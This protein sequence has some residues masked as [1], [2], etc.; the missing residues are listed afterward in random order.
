MS[1]FKNCE[2][3]KEEIVIP[4][5]LK[6]EDKDHYFCCHGCQTV[7]EILHDKKLQ[8]YYKFRD[9]SEKQSFTPIKTTNNKFNYLDQ[10]DFRNKYVKSNKNSYTLIFY[11][12]GIH[13]LACLWLIEKIPEFV[14]HVVASKLNMAK[15]TAEIT[16]T[17]EG[18]FATVAKQL[19]TLGYPPHPIMEDEDS[20]KLSQKEDHSQLIKIAISFFCAGNIMLMSFSV[21]AGATGAIKEYFD[22]LSLL[23]AIP[24]LTYSSTSFYKNAYS[25]VKNK[26]LSI[27]FPIVVAIILGSIFSAEQ[28]LTNGTHIYYDSLTTL[29]FLLL[30][31]RYLLKKMQQKGLSAANV[32]S[33]FSTLLATKIG[34]NGEKTQVLASFL[35]KDEF[36]LVKPGETIP[37]DG[38]ISTGVS[39]TNNSLISGESL[40]VNVKKGDHVFSGTINL[41]HDLEIIVQTIAEKS[42]LGNILKS[43]EK[44]W[45]KKTQIT[46]FTDTVSRYFVIIVFSI[47]LITFSYFWYS[48]NLEAAITRALTLIIITCP[49]ALGL[50][51]PLSL[52]L[53][54]AKFAKLGI[55]VKDESVIEKITQ[56]KNIIFDKTGTL[57]YGRFKVVNVINHIKEELAD[58]IIYSLEK[59]SKHPIAISIREYLFYQAKEAQK[60]LSELEIQEYTE[61]I[62]EGPQG[63]I[64]NKKYQVKGIKHSESGLTKIGLFIDKNLIKEFHLQDIV[65]SDAKVT[66]NRIKKFIPNHFIL[67]GDNESAVKTVEKELGFQAHHCFANQTPEDKVKFIQKHPKSIMIGDG[68]NDAIA[69]SHALTGIAVHG[70]VDISLRA[71]DVFMANHRLEN[72]EKLIIGSHQTLKIIKRN[73]IFSLLYNII[74]AILAIG[75][76]ITPLLAAILMPLS[77]FTV[78]IST[79]LSTKEFRKITKS[80]L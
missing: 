79:F 18:S 70:S 38:I 57:T 43:V 29:V 26:V 75:G 50:T 37:T 3:C 49:C 58:E 72:I 41:S 69:L 30:T 2:H 33:F 68:A 61:I 23:L 39:Q 9:Q 13:C 64:D 40:P 42:K 47:A 48:H 56:A 34:K 62:G 15:S 7:Y 80:E 65:K 60:T 8:Q 45:N 24:A 55:I 22:L 74:G 78:L 67:S 16:I 14:P 59:K 52:T 71:S 1:E 63:I 73:L 46:R 35:K 76:Y 4:S 6:I 12:E 44:G 10:E 54:L 11:L 77:S 53:T 5:I 21:Y 28:A 25:S 20:T 51:T 31:S 19:E 32:S 27:D 36:V 17:K 66:L